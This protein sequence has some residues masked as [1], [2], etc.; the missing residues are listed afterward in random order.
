MIDYILA[1]IISFLGVMLGGVLALIAPEE[2][3]AGKK[4]WKILEWILLAVIAGVMLY[5]AGFTSWT[6]VLAAVLFALKF[7]KNEYP[8]LIFVLVISLY[9]HL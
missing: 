3:K 8:A 2:L 7:V 5:F 4:W 6:I 9:H 1:L